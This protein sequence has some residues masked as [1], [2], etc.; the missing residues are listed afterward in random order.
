MEQSYTI[1]KPLVENSSKQDNT[2]AV[3]EEHRL[4]VV[5]EYSIPVPQGGRQLLEQSGLE[6]VAL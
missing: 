3:V 2:Q 4:L 1:D 5:V 6:F